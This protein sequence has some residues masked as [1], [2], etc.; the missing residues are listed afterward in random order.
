[1]ELGNFI[2]IGGIKMHHTSLDLNI[3]QIC[4]IL[5][6]NLQHYDTKGSCRINFFRTKASEIYSFISQKDI[7]GYDQYC[8]EK[9]E[10]IDK[11]ITDKIYLSIVKATTSMEY[12][13]YDLSTPTKKL[14]SCIVE[15]KKLTT[16]K[17]AL[18]TIPKNNPNT[19]ILME[20]YDKMRFNKLE[21]L[22]Q[23]FEKSVEYFT[24]FTNWIQ[25]RKN[26]SIGDSASFEDIKD[27]VVHYYVDGFDKGHSP[28]DNFIY[29]YSSLRKTMGNPDKNGIYDTLLCS[30]I[31]FIFEKCDIFKKLEK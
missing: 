25:D 24:C 4:C 26:V 7:Q 10:N 12:D 1:M 17:K 29:I 6:E 2:F 20:Y 11:N 14:L 5:D 19:K 8:V 23:L 9:L 21:S 13:E 22:E 16:K 18:K 30:L 27:L 31:C 3:L 15:T 28:V